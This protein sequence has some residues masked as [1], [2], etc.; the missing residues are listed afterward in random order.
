[1]KLRRG[2][3]RALATVA[4]LL[5]I[6]AA[7][8]ALIRA[9]PGDPIETLLAESGTSIPIT[10]LKSELGLDKP[11]FP[12]LLDDLQ[13]AARGDW[14]KSLLS[15]QPIGP[16]LWERWIQTAALALLSMM[17]G[18]SISL[19]LG[20]RSAMQPGGAWDRF[21]TFYGSLTAALP[22]PWIGPVLLLIFA[23][24]IPVFPVSGSIWLPAFTLS[25]AFSG[26]WS[27]LIRS[28]LQ[29]TLGAPATIAARARGLSERR[30]VIKY[31]L[32]PAAGALLAYL[33]TQFGAL[34][35]GAFVTEVLF[36][37]R[38]MGSLLVEG[39]LKRDYP[40]VEAAVFATAAASLLGNILGDRL[41]TWFDPR[42]RDGDG[43]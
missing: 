11:F 39:V 23:V 43:S 42:L 6:F 5:F 9:L 10:E 7:T 15:R 8:R 35:G 25:L 1:M 18:I 38:G 29:E 32:A 40:V 27:R 13:Q 30:I 12:S 4:M 20:L 36:G 33:G 19:W 28:R 24:K 34:L 16:I 26:L 22:T 21:C 3:T 41:Q 37:W 31:G 14:G 17:F 2:I